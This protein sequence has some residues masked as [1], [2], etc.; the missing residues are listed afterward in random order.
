MDQN[1]V[2]VT[3][4]DG[5]R[6]CYG[7]AGHGPVLVKAANWLTHVE[8]DWHSPIWR[9]TAAWRFSPEPSDAQSTPLPPIANCRRSWYRKGAAC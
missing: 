4:K 7:V 9:Q 6:I 3:A 1:L 2:Y 5:T 8:Y